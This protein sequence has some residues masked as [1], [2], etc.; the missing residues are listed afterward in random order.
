MGTTWNVL[1]N[2][3]YINTNR[4]MVLA[5]WNVHLKVAN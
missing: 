1:E 4:Y 3:G 2:Q 5:T